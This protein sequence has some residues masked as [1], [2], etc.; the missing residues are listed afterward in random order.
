TPVGGPLSLRDALPILEG[1]GS[2]PEVIGLLRMAAGD[3]AGA[4]PHLRAAAFFA[5]ER[6]AMGEA[7]ELAGAALEASA[8][9]SAGAHEVGHLR[10]EE[11][12]SEL[13]SREKLV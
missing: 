13:Q 4:Y 10:S 9:I 8:A 11:H 3:P 1:S 5:A 6:A 7:H 2:R 12:T